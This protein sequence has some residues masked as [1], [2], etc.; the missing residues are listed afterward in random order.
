M[1]EQDTGAR[2]T[3]AAIANR[4]STW[5]ICKTK[6]QQ[7][8]PTATYTRCVF[9]VLFPPKRSD[10]TDYCRHQSTPWLWL[11]HMKSNVTPS[12]QRHPATHAG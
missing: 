8:T 1:L 6:K 12:A 7:P 10:S 9:W 11:W 4:V 5:M 2:L 3:A